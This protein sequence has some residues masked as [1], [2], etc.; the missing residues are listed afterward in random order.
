MAVSDTLKQTRNKLN[1][2]IE[3]AP[4]VD[5]R[6]FVGGQSDTVFKEPAAKLQRKPKAETP[7]AAK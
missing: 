7:K 1:N 3:Q 5:S 2:V 4:S 6:G